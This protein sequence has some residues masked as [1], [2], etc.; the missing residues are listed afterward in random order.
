MALGICYEPLLRWIPGD[1]TVVAADA[2]VFGVHRR[3]GSGGM[4]A[5]SIPESLTVLGRWGEKTRLIMHQTSVEHGASRCLY[6]LVGSEGTLEFDANAQRLSL[7]AKGGE[8]RE[9]EVPVM[10]NQGWKV[11]AD[12]VN[13]IRTGAPV[14]LT[15]FETGR[16]YMAF[17]DAVWSAWAGR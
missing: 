7:H 12:F 1:A 6:R 5:V 16:R 14:S 13:S 15:D 4:H 9:I 3:D 17:T 11:E 10:V 2:Q 8:R